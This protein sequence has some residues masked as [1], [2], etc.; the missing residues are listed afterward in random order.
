MFHVFLSTSAHSIEVTDNFDRI[1]TLE[2]PA[3]RIISLAPHTT[4]N[5]FSAG[6]GDRIIAV[7][8][9]SDYPEAANA[10]PSLGS[11]AQFSIETI[12]SM[13]PDL[14]VAWRGGNNG[15]ALDQLERLG[16]TI[17]YSEPRS[18]DDILVNI[19]NF[20]KLADS[21]DKMDP[22]VN[23][24]ME[25]ITKNRKQFQDRSP[26]TVFYQVWSDPLMTLNGEHFITHVLEVCGAVNLFAEL[27]IIAPRV[28]I[29]SV[30]AANP[31]AIVTGTNDDNPADMSMWHKWTSINAVKHNHF[32][33]VDS[34]SMHRHT[35]RMLNS[36]EGFCRQIDTVR[37]ASH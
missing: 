12:V 34:D 33:F 4:E 2:K 17:Y 16:M 35:M 14:I 18:F 37:Q 15:E 23:Q 25:T 24:I 7:V 29:E 11:Y 36:I 5:L 21:E 10:L 26:V 6:A 32:L 1:I 19:R 27:P 20:S 30:I 3:N 13:Q 9:Y 28:D 22:S 8:E 31:D